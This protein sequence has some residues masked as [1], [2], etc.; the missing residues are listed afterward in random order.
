MLGFTTI[1]SIV[2]W[3]MFDISYVNQSYTVINIHKPLAIHLFN[4]EQPTS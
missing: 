3:Q 4:F 1:I 2:T